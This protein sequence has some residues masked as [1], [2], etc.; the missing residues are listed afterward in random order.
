MDKTFRVIIVA[1]LVLWP[2]CGNDSGQGAY[3]DL[4]VNSPEDILTPAG[5]TITLRSAIDSAASGQVIRF[6]PSLDGATLDL[7]IVGEAH[8]VLKGEVMGMRMEESGLVSYLEGYFDRDYGASALYA[9]K[10]VVIDASNLPLGIT[11]RWNNPDTEARVLGV[12][13]NLTMANVSMTGGRSVAQDIS[14]DNPDQ[15]FTLAR[16]GALAVWGRARLTNCRLFDNHCEGDFGQSRDRGAFGGGIYAENVNLIDCLISGNTV[17]GAGAA[18]GGVYTLGGISPLTAGSVVD[19]CTITGNR[20]SGIFVY[21]AGVYSD[22][23]G[24]GNRKVLTVTQSTLARN[25]A[26]PSA[27]LPIFLLGMGYW[28]GGGVYMSNGYLKMSACTVVENETFGYPRTDDL[29]KSNLAGGIAATIGNAHAV[30][31][32]MIGQSIVC[33]NTV[34]ELNPADGTV[35]LSYAHDI[36]TGSLLYF[37]SQGYNLL[38]VT[39]FSQILVPVG[40]KDW[41][42]LCRKH[43]PKNGDQAG[44]LVE[45]VLDLGSGVMV[46]DMI[47]S[48]GVDEGQPTVLYYEPKGDALGQIPGTPYVVSET[49]AEYQV[50][51]SVTDNFL[52]ILLQRLEDLYDIN[53]F[54]LDFTDDFELFLQSVDT[55]ADVPDNQPYTDPD[56]QPVLSLADTHWYGPA[57]TWPKAVVNYP[58][59]EFWHRLDS[60]LGELDIPDM[61]AEGLGD[62]AWT[63]LFSTGPL[64]ENTGITIAIWQAIYSV[65]PLGV[66]QLGHVRAMHGPWDIGAIEMP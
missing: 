9:Q 61:G 39:D 13:G 3:P 47:L 28:R 1:F 50:A 46:S 65:T 21:G 4:V 54:A 52:S 32:M 51:D 38:G 30:E 40:E 8:S 11:I 19:R 12:Y 66:D 49:M 53:G 16:G 14:D 63:A 10:D 35:A 55:D 57:E 2:G 41:A 7:S 20:I 25:L 44:V 27:D 15:P 64:A 23:G 62:D 37:K 22:G 60:A 17:L 48:A 29:G 59:I 6:D 36:F 45:D 26:E 33:G 58:Y 43:F 31:S 5:D 42:S 18:G 24:I 56:G 34:N